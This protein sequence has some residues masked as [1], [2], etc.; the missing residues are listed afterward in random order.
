MSNPCETPFS[1]HP[2]ASESKFNFNLPET[3]YDQIGYNLIYATI[4]SFT[5]A[6]PKILESYL[7]LEAFSAKPRRVKKPLKG[8]Q[9]LLLYL[10]CSLQARK[11]PF[12]FIHFLLGVLTR[13]ICFCTMKNV[14]NETIKTCFSS[15]VL[16][17]DCIYFVLASSWH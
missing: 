10:L 2:M 9:S 15:N 11:Y 7:L 1:H 14:V 6:N 12:G 5:P 13:N 17:S 16:H 4:N 3:V 8:F